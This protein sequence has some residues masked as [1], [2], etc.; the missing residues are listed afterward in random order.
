MDET[1]ARELLPIGDDN[2][3]GPNYGH[4]MTWKPGD[5]DICLDST[6]DLEELEAIVWWMQN[7]G[8]P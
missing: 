8:K 7:K 5:A 3:I 6:F 2:S 4:Y 1:R